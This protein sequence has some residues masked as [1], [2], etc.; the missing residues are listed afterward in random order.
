V[1][2]EVLQ[3]LLFQQGQIGDVIFLA[4]GAIALA[5][6]ARRKS[7][8]DARLQVPA[9]VAALAVVQTAIIWLSVGTELDRLGM[10]PAVEIRIA[11]WAIAA[12][13]LDRV[14]TRSEAQVTTS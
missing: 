3:N 14:L 1:L 9:Y 2:P 8:R 13:S 12:F 6:V 5:V 10:V 11:F 4:G 7:G